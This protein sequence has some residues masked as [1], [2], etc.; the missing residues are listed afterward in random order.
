MV[1]QPEEQNHNHRQARVVIHNSD[2]TDSKIIRVLQV[3]RK[4]AIQ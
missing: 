4:G 3:I 1:L 2:K